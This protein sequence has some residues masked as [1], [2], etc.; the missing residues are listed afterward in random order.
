MWSDDVAVAASGM[1]F[2]RFGSGRPV[3]LVHGIPGSGACWRAVA[4]RL[5]AG[6]DVVVPDLLGFGD[7]ARPRRLDDLHAAA[8]AEALAGLLA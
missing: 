4:E 1:A 5:P 7:S 8:Q 3:V 6:L 2:R